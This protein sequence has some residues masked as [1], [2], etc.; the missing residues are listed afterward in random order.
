M[1]TSGYRSFSLSLLLIILLFSCSDDNMQ[2]L[3]R[4]YIVITFDDQH[5]SIYDIAL[6]IMDD[7]GFRATNAINTGLIG[8]P[9][10]LNWEQVEKLEFERGWETAGHSLTH[11][12]LPD[13]TDEEVLFEIEQ[14]WLNLRNR[15]LSH[16]TFVLPRGHATQRDYE[17]I[18]RFYNNIRNSRDIRMFYPLD[19]NNIGYFPYINSYSFEDV[20]A[21]ITEGVLG[22]ENLIIIG[23][24]RFN[25]PSH[26]HNCSEED[27]REILR[28][29]A[30]QNLP[31]IT[32]K[33]A[34][35]MLR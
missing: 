4:T 23:F 22:R 35:E 32:I 3:N 7:F 9:S 34:A 2:M 26:S 20:I 29:I 33:E 8:A 12:N 30:N 13:C 28:F 18:R 21:R 1:K 25:D 6:P 24:H 5:S 17:I 16:E 14:D 15:G 10:R 27:F 31:V 11:A 19:R